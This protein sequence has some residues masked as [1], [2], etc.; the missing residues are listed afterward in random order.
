[1]RVSGQLDFDYL[2]QQLLTV[3]G[4]LIERLP[5]TDALKANTLQVGRITR[6]ES[7][8]FSSDK[9]FNMAAMSV[10]PLG[11]RR[12]YEDLAAS[13]AALVNEILESRQGILAKAF[14]DLDFAETAG[15]GWVDDLADLKLAAGTNITYR[16]EASDGLKAILEL[17]TGQET[18]VSPAP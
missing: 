12:P 18:L 15:L 1:M 2:N 11:F 10:V 7:Y 13:K 14:T 16:L 17:T 6:L 8:A 3:P 5:A 9:I 4:T